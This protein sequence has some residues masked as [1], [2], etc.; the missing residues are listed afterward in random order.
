MPSNDI[1]W[2][3][4]LSNFRKAYNQLDDAIHLRRE[5]RLSRLEEQGVIQAFEYTYEL[6]WNVLRDFLQWQGIANLTGSRDS[7]RE[8]F[9]AGLIESGEVWMQ[10][11]QDRNRTSHTY[12]EETATQIL[13]S[14]DGQYH[15]LFQQLEQR[16]SRE[17]SE[18]GLG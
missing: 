18:R 16:M 10:M 12:N 1:R 11:L 2:V 13:N 9:N 8:A 3:Q 14:I 5:R 7:I 15:E 17:V 4:R 6:A